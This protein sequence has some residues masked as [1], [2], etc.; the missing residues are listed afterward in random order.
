MIP[1]LMS[2]LKPGF[3]RLFVT[4]QQNRVKTQQA[5]PSAGF[6]A[7]GSKRSRLIGALALACYGSAF[8][9]AFAD[10]CQPQWIAEPIAV[11]AAKGEDQATHLEADELTQPN[12]NVLE[13]R[14]NARI[15]QPG[16]V[17]LANE[18][19]YHKAEQQA[20]AFGQVQLHREDVMMTATEAHL[21]NQA[22]TA[23]LQETRYQIKQNRAHGQAKSIQLDKQSEIADL[24]NATLTTCPLENIK[25]GLQ[26]DSKRHVGEQVAWEL[27]FDT[28]QI[29]NQTRRVVGHN[30][31]LFFKGL[32]VFYTPYFDFP[33][34]DRASGLLIPEFGGY[35]AI[36]EERSSFYVRLPYYFNLA[37]N[38]D[39][40]LSLLYM[41]NRGPILE[42]EF[43]Y[44]LDTR[45]IRHSAEFTVTLLNDAQT[46][47]EGLAYIDNSGNIY[48]GDK[49]EQ[50]WRGK[51]LANQQWNPNLRS[52]IVWHETS[53]ENFFADIPVESAFKSVTSTPRWARIDY[54][55]QNWQAYAQVYSYLR[56][57]DAA[58]NYEKR[59]EVGLRYRE[60]FGNFNLNVATEATEFDIPLSDPQKPE[61]LRTRLAPELSVSLRR[62]WGHLKATAIANGLNYAMHDNG[63]NTSGENQ[64]QHTVM[65]YALQG[66]LVFERDWQFGESRYVQ[67][68]EPTLQ[69][70]HVPY[71][72]QSKAPLFDT[73]TKSLDFSNLFALNRFSGY[74]RIGDTT[75]VSAALTS[76]LLTADGAPFLEAGIGQIYYLADR[77]VALG[78]DVLDTT[79][80]SDYFAKLAMTGGDLAFSSTS[81]FD[82][83]DLALV[84]TNSRV[85]WQL[86]DK[87]K[88]LL[89]YIL[90]NNNTAN[91]QATL[92]LGGTVRLNRNWE[93]GTYWN[94]DFTH[95]VRNE[96]Q[97]A[98]R[99]D[100]CCW[101]AEFSLEETQL[102]NGLYNY[103]VQFM[104]EFKGLSASGRT[105]KN[106]LDN[107]LNF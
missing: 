74:D 15:A 100:D 93:L 37:P 101:A 67:T 11:P 95:E 104:I 79:T 98:A 7:P 25:N 43:R 47:D 88:V 92:G 57:R 44:L 20:H 90:S 26:P 69:Y 6:F 28:L 49:I 60:R 62:P 102:E 8:N 32:P 55:N 105:F 76:K 50:R 9:A 71:V 61:A 46:A 21:N 48:Y 83:T 39:D 107:K 30:T 70:L 10:D 73:T 40:T 75:Q 1:R 94:Y 29:N 51:L 24:D 27:E 66:G 56:L 68:L 38:Y 89:N 52:E 12:S 81:Q 82:K 45:G 16:T 53:D 3:Y 86:S 2:N 41:E 80:E 13:L 19:Q 87:N 18:V 31:T 78:N 59:P 14:G 63:Y 72:N 5:T 4:R 35:K 36:T 33:L 96:V 64:I 17:L 99:Y 77:K 42:N 84:N 103:S 85:H 54:T 106:Y 91:E 22:Q 65:Q 97:Y 34:D 58:N 23:E